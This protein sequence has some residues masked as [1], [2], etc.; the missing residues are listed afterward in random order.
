[1]NELAHA[2]DTLNKR[3]EVNKIAINAINKQIEEPVILK[4]VDGKAKWSC[5]KCGHIVES[6]LRY[7]DEC[8]QKIKWK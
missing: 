4:N 1:M 2:I 3:I 5:G 6:C 8:G 7:C